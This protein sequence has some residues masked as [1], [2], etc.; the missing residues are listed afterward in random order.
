LCIRRGSFF[1]DHFL[2]IGTYLF[3]G[4]T[5]VA[6]L[7]QLKKAYA[8]LTKMHEALD[9]K[10]DKLKREIAEGKKA[11]AR[12]MQLRLNFTVLVLLLLIFCLSFV[13]QQTEQRQ[14]G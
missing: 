1:S 13:P 9:S 8:R 5:A 4:I 10:Q 2:P 3:V 6:D 12:E 14:L 11:T 7:N